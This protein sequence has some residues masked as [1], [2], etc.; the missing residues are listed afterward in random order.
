MAKNLQAKLPPSDSVSL[1]DINKDAT[2]KLADE[3]RESQAG[4]ASVRLAESA[5]DAARDAVCI[6]PRPLFP[7]AVSLLLASNDEHVLSMI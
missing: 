7:H 4:G 2:R 1:Y 5:Q 3:M 6:S